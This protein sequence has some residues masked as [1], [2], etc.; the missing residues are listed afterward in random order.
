MEH[1]DQ[2]A[3]LEEMHLDKHQYTKLVEQ[4]LRD[5]DLLVVMTLLA[6]ELVAVEQAD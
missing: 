4:E 1:T 6:T 2:A 3:A 5:K